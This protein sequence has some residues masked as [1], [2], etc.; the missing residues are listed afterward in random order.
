MIPSEYRIKE[1]DCCKY[2]EGL[3]EDMISLSDLD[4]FGWN[5]KATEHLP[6]FLTISFACRKCGKENSIK[7]NREFEK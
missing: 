6:S 4:W 7:V 2:S 1:P 3:V 5:E